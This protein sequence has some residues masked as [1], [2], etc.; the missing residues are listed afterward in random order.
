MIVITRQGS[1]HKGSHK[2]NDTLGLSPFIASEIRTAGELVREYPEQLRRKWRD[3]SSSSRA[4]VAE[5]RKK[6]IEIRLKLD[7]REVSWA[8]RLI[9]QRCAS[10]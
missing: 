10:V 3:S 4:E 6:G 2:K 8:Q 9:L 5:R 7:S 1:A